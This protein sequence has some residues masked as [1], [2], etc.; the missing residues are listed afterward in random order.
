MCIRTG[1]HSNP[2]LNIDKD[3]HMYLHVCLCVRVCVCMRER[4]RERERLGDIEIE[5]MR[6]CISYA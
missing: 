1:V 3:A 2:Y 6:E 4:E 5:R